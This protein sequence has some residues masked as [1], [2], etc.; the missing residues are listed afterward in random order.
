MAPPAL[1]T[2]DAWLAVEGPTSIVELAFEQRHIHYPLVEHHSVLCAVLCAV[3]RFSLKAVKPLALFDSKVSPAPRTASRDERRDSC[4]VLEVARY[5]RDA[6][7]RL[8][9]SLGARGRCSGPRGRRRRPSRASGPDLCPESEACVST[10]WDSP[11]ALDHVLPVPPSL[12]HARHT[13]GAQ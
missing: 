13:P 11:P 6:A 10:E 4:A 1:D 5:S 12:C 2:E 8:S 9:L 7:G 3:M